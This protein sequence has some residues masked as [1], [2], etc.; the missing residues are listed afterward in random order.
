VVLEGKTRRQ[1]ADEL[2]LTEHTIKFH[3]R[4]IYKRLGVH[5]RADAAQLLTA[6]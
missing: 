2:W 4:N 3:L 1:A 6:N 5:N